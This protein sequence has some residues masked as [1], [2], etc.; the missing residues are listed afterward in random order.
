MVVQQFLCFL[1]NI[2]ITHKLHIKKFLDTAKTN[3]NMYPGRL[4]D[5]GSS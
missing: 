5:S 3:E 2:I 1:F 4:Y